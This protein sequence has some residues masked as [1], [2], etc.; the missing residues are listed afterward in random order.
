MGDN[1]LSVISTRTNQV[2]HTVHLNAGSFPAVRPNGVKVS[3]DG[4]FI[5][6]A[7]ETS[8]NLSVV[9]TK[10]M[11]VVTTVALPD[12][13]SPVQLDITDDGG[14]ALTA[15]GRLLVVCNAGDNTVSII[16]TSSSEVIGTIPTGLWPQY[17]VILN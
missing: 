5:Y 7:N 11:Q 3:P 10:Q 16:D 6:V 2:V 14:L 8:H 13:S 17:A 15:D 4:K 12:G 1:S 9:D